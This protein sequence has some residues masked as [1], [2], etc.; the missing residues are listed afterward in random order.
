MLN[1]D[2][3]PSY[4]TISAALQ[5]RDNITAQEKSAIALYTVAAPLPQTATSSGASNVTIC[6]REQSIERIR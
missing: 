3:N 6:K 1:L 4:V 2:R 5:H